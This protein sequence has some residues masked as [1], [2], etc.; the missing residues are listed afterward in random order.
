MSLQLSFHG[1][2]QL[3]LRVQPAMVGTNMSPHP[4]QPS[5]AQAA[6]KMGMEQPEMANGAVA[7][8][9]APVLPGYKS[10]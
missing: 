1:V 10:L 3:G 7:P 4:N 9:P 5:T 2:L 6:M 8:V